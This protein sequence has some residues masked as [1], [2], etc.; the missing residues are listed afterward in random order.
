[1]ECRVSGGVQYQED[2]CQSE[3]NKGVH[4]SKFLV[5]KIFVLFVL[6][7]MEG[8]YADQFI[9]QVNTL[10]APFKFKYVKEA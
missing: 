6:Y 1:L 5:D 3:R 10:G 8:K 9:Q 4:M 2:P 7:G